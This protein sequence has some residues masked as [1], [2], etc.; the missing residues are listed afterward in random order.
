M[1]TK[2]SIFWSSFCG[3]FD[4]IWIPKE[5]EPFLTG[6][7]FVILGDRTKKNRGGFHLRLFLYSVGVIPRRRLKVA[8]KE[9]LS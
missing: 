5:K 8:A 1:P 9:E 2:K 4:G 6:S 7:F 3:N